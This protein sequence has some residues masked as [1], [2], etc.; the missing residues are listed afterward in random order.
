[1]SRGD[2][3]CGLRLLTGHERDGAGR[4]GAVS[5]GGLG[6]RSLRPELIVAVLSNVTNPR[7]RLVAALL[8]DFQ[9]P[10]LGSRPM[11]LVRSMNIE[12]KTEIKAPRIG[13]A[14]SA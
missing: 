11:V 12:T 8:D 4:A 3:L 7:Q 1:M 5:L 14:T 2:Q 13:T 10:H 6:C 9:V